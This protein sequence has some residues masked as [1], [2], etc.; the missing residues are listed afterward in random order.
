M[1][2]DPT[3]NKN[4]EHPAM[5]ENV[6]DDIVS[7]L[8]EFSESRIAKDNQISLLGSG[9][10]FPESIAVASMLEEEYDVSVTVWSAPSFSELKR[11]GASAERWNMLRP[12]REP[13]ASFVAEKFAN[14]K[15]PAIAATDY[16]RGL[17]EMIRPYMPVAYHTL[18]TDGFGRSDTREALRD[19]FEVDCRW[20]TVCAL[21]TLADEG[22]IKHKVV[23]EAIN[24]YGID[25]EKPEPI[26]H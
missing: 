9:T 1:Y 15:G 6:E 2:Y 3:M 16:V 14:A 20:I 25:P 24:K 8:Y 13:K 10:I 18:G 4:H 19:F 5:P 17:P 7:G 11:N 26:T 23:G 12:D 21:K 22:R